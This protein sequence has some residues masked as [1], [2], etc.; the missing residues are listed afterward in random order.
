MMMRSAPAVLA[1]PMLLR[2]VLKA[3]LKTAMTA[4]LGTALPPEL[5]QAHLPKA[6]SAR[7]ALQWMVVG[8][9]CPRRLVDRKLQAR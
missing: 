6:Q 1:T 3:V 8:W 2:T 7:R 4:A 9:E 5:L